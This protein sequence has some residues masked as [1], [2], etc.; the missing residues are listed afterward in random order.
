MKA[1]LKNRR[2]LLFIKNLE[3]EIIPFEA[4]LENLEI[5][6]IGL[7]QDLAD[8]EICE[9]LE[10]KIRLNLS[11]GKE[12]F[13]AVLQRKIVHTSFVDYNHALGVMFFGGFTLPEFRGRHIN[14]AVKSV[15]FRYLKD[16]GIKKAYI[17]CS[18]DNLNSKASII[19]VGFKKL[20]LWQRIVT[21]IRIWIKQ[22]KFIIFT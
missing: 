17:S 6:R 7:Q 21:K 14:P 8:F 9:E 19:K 10:K 4:E 13:A 15:I 3:E 11:P 5:K 20:S 1:F 18:K 22:A 12:V 2:G 16:T